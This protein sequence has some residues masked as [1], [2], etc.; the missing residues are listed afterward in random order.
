MD[1]REELS[2]HLTEEDL[3]RVIIYNAQ[4]DSKAELAEL[5]IENATEIY[6]LGESTLKNLGETYHD[7]LNM[8]CVNMI[9]DYLDNINNKNRTD[10]KKLSIESK[11]STDKPCDG[12]TKRTA[13]VVPAIEIV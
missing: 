3:K 8:K 9:A 11:E 12:T 1:V 13:F 7:A 2:S 10:K 5:F 6:I 4:R